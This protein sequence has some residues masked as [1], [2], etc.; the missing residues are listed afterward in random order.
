MAKTEKYVISTCYSEYETAKGFL[1]FEKQR[2]TTFRRHIQNETIQYYYILITKYLLSLGKYSVDFIKL[3]LRR[4]ISIA[5]YMYYR[6]NLDKD[7][8][9]KAFDEIIDKNINLDNLKNQVKYS[10][11]MSLDNPFWNLYI[12]KDYDIIMDSISRLS[13]EKEETFALLSTVLDYFYY[14]CKFADLN[15]YNR[16]DLLIAYCM[17]NYE[18]S[19]F[20]FAPQDEEY[21]KNWIST[22]SFKEKDIKERILGH[23]IN[24]I[25]TNNNLDLKKEMVVM[26]RYYYEMMLNEAYKHPFQNRY[27][28]FEVDFQNRTAIILLNKIISP[29]KFKY[30][31]KNYIFSKEGIVEEK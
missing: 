16:L 18:F 12:G 3:I 7:Y 26:P 25:M 15:Y 30:N 5:V 13:S 27:G 8:K 22:K 19:N 6:D 21:L 10:G 29:F 28:F 20:I 1:L 23:I 2:M 17:N 4:H 24:I 31:D 9:I 11:T 14:G